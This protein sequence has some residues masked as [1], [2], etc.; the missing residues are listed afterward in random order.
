MCRHCTVSL[1]WVLYVSRYRWMNNATKFEQIWR[2]FLMV[3]TVLPVKSFPDFLLS[4]LAI[5]EINKFKRASHYQEQY[6][7][8]FLQLFV[9]TISQSIFFSCENVF[10]DVAQIPWLYVKNE[11]LTH[12]KERKKNIMEAR[13]IEYRSCF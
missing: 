11:P 2:D 9:K 10:E 6:P 4:F 8:F 12:K 5:F 13:T 3:G 7:G 1:L